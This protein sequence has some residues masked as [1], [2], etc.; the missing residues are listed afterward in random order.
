MVLTLDIGNTNISMGAVDEDG[1][2]FSGRL[3]A[4]KSRSTD[5]YAVLLRLIAD[6]HGFDLRAVEGAIISSVVPQLTPVLRDAVK[7]AAGKTPLVVGPGV[8]SGLNIRIDDPAELGADFVAAAVAACASY[9]LPCITI[10]MGTAT[11]LGV[12]DGNGTYI[13]GAIS[14]GVM[15]SLDALAAGTS[16]LPHVSLEAPAAAIGRSTVSCMKSGLV[17]GTAAMLD[18]LIDRFEEQLGQTASV[19]ATGDWAEVI[20]PHCRRNDILIDPELN[21]RGLWLIWNKN[22]RG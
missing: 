20:I 16:Q 18:G 7:F 21:M 14:P 5:E 19:V 6:Q 22:K 17:F 4:V 11:A 1:I 10:D 12:L 15:V 13:G 2:I 8:K 9:P 3:S